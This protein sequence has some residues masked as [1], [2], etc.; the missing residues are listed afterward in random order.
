MAEIL[1]KNSILVKSGQFLGPKIHPLITLLSWMTK[2]T[3]VDPLGKKS[4][5]TPALRHEC[6]TTN[7]LKDV[8]TDIHIEIINKDGHND[9]FNQL[10]N[11]G[12]SLNQTSGIGGGKGY[13][14][15]THL[16]LKFFKNT[17]P[18]KSTTT[19]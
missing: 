17:S 4:F 9:T 7:S 11:G 13:F 16:G 12:V 14:W 10:L 6:N 18:G 15:Y 8:L 2:S 3:P 5:P 19:Q 1:C